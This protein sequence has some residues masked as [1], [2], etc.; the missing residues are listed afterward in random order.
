VGGFLS[1]RFPPGATPRVTF[2]QDEAIYRSSQLNE[3]CWMIDGQQTLRSKSEGRGR[4][5][6][7]MC[8]REFGFGFVIS[9][10]Q[11]ATINLLRQGKLYADEEAATY[12]LGNPQK[13]ELTE[14]PFIRFLEYGAT[15]DGYWSYRHMVLQIEDCIDCLK[16]LLPNFEYVFELDHS[17]GHAKKQDDGLTTERSLLL[18]KHGGQQQYMRSSIMTEKT[19]GSVGHDRFLKLGETQSMVFVED[20]SP[21][22]LKPDC[23]KY[24]TASG[25]T[26]TRELNVAELRKGLE[27]MGL[28]TAGKQPQLKER[29]AN[30][31]LP[32]TAAV[33]HMTDSYVGKQ[34]GAAQIG[35]ERGEY[36]ADL[37]LP[38]GKKVS[39]EGTAI[40]D[41]QPDNQPVE[42]GIVDHRK[43]KKKKVRR[44]LSTSVRH[45]LS[46]HEDFANEKPR[47]AKILEDTLGA[48]V[49]LTPKCHPELAGRGIE[50][51]WGYSK[52]R[53]RRDIND[54][55]SSHLVENVKKALTREILTTSRIRKYARKARDYKLTYLFLLETTSED[56]GTAGKF[57][58]EHIKKMVKTHRSAIG[59]DYSFIANS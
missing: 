10:Q 19:T 38:N 35:F 26:S 56:D 16:V 17:S 45:I 6:S 48:F 51:A 7:A 5:V 36:D 18:W 27:A 50:Y 55:I 52:L 15:K 20:D 41:A 21:P 28:N 47:L 39:M 13:S 9:R 58:I 24:P 22:I 40:A 57:R 30:A 49:R 25:V 4:M 29:S 34:K 59:A 32:T 42:E 12:L 46:L 44:D 3:S 23:P 54:A 37:L 43:K 53:Y 1:V 2:G 31:N 14:S 8:S 11:L 33:I